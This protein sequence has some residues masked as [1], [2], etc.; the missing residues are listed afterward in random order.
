MSEPSETAP[1]ASS[2]GTVVTINFTVTSNQSPDDGARAVPAR[3]IEK[4]RARNLPPPPD[5][6]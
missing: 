4:R 1:P 2:G 5:A 3:L 6:A